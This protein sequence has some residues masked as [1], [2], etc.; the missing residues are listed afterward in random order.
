MP[1]KYY[2][3]SRT[4][5]SIPVLT[6]LLL[7]PLPLSLLCSSQV[8]IQYFDVLTTLDERARMCGTFVCACERCQFE[9]S[10][11]A[12]ADAFMSHAVNSIAPVWLRVT[13]PD[14]GTV[15]P[16]A[17]DQVRTATT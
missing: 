9:G 12:L 15:E 17:R 8:T 11:G 5:Q 13:S 14:K 16:A 1:V 3:S 7:L 4:N 10:L 6:L 2:M